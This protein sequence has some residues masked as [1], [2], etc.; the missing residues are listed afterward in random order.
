[1]F[2]FVYKIP[3]STTR[4]RTATFDEEMY[5]RQY[6]H[7]VIN[8]CHQLLTRIRKLES[9]V[10][11]SAICKV[12]GE[13]EIHLQNHSTVHPESSINSNA[14]KRNTV[15][16]SHNKQ[17]PGKDKRKSVIQCCDQKPLIAECRG[18][19]GLSSA[20]YLYAVCTDANGSSSDKN[21]SKPRILYTGR[22]GTRR[23]EFL[24]NFFCLFAAK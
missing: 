8:R 19:D 9:S 6:Q 5:I 24:K 23:H 15:S 11:S 13:A 7:R 1:M 12:P 21:I 22:T 16:C 20:M 4:Q 10:R 3:G 18:D 2:K 17:I 14:L